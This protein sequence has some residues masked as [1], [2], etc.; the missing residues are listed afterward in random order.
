M[1]TILIKKPG[2]FEIIEIDTPT[3]KSDEILIEVK[4]LS[5]CN[6]H[7]WKVNKGRYQNLVYLE[8][9]V[10]GFP[11][12]EGAGVV[13]EVGNDVKD[14]EVGDHVAMSGLGGPPLY[15]EFVTRKADQVVQ[16]EK[17]VPLEQVAMAEL[18]GCVH[19]ACKKVPDYHGKSVAISGCGPGGLAA[20]QI[21]KVFG[22]DRVTAIDVRP[23]RLLLAREFG[24][25]AIIDAKNE[26]AIAEFKKEGAQIIIECTGNLQ[27]YQNAFHIAREAVVIFGYTEGALEIPLWPLFDHE[28]T[29]YN[30]KWLTVQDLQ[31]AVNLIAAGKIRTDK[32]ISARVD[33]E[34]YLDAIEMIGSGEVIK[35]IMIP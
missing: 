19:R 10:P 6:Q 34:H 3:P 1:K 16:V 24:A 8:Y 30:S 7:D 12:H 28:L 13:V 9:G 23:Q 4:A 32:M 15:S 25:D 27:A 17:H 35:V 2:A 31:A 18:I 11:G 29:I 14:F 20:L 33:F 22:A 5:L 21:V 26:K